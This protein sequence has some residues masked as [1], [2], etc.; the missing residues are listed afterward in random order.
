LLKPPL[1]DF[2]TLD[3][4][5][6]MEELDC[7]GETSA[8]PWWEVAPFHGAAPS[9]S[10]PAPEFAHVLSALTEREP[11]NHDDDSAEDE[12]ALSYEGLLR[13]QACIR[14]GSQ[15]DSSAGNDTC[16]PNDVSLPVPGTCQS[17]PAP[18]CFSV[19]VRLSE[20]ENVQ[21]RQRAA[22]AGLTVSAY[23]RSCV[24]EAET[25]RAQ[26]KEALAQLREASEEQRSA[27]HTPRRWWRGRSRRDQRVAQ[28]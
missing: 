16:D 5:P 19:T 17:S 7:S 25:L 12:V 23:L 14:L 27:P 15:S 24:L 4:M 11:H 1:A 28:L 9:A 8:P 3:P 22:E 26:V 21:L 13:A 10:N 2:D 6:V 18:K 20:A